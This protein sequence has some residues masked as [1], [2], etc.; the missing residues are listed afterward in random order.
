MRYG[1]L[2]VLGWPG[3]WNALGWRWRALRALRLARTAAREDELS[4]PSRL[5]RSIEQIF[6]YHETLTMKP[7]PEVSPWKF[8]NG[9][10]FTTI[11]WLLSA[12]AVLGAFA[13]IMVRL[14]VEEFGG[15]YPPGFIYFL[16]WPLLI[17][18]AFVSYHGARL[19]HR[20]LVLLFPLAGAVILLFTLRYVICIPGQCLAP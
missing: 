1:V 9:A 14:S 6:A 17:A 13:F 12:D 10:L 20:W 19:L 16:M 3:P 15:R 7:G 4:S 11:G 2:I 5:R 18:G 8:S